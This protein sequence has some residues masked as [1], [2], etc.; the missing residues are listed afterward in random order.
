M[1]LRAVLVPV[2]LLLAG[3]PEDDK[4]LLLQFPLVL[5][6]SGTCETATSKDFL[7]LKEYAVRLTFMHRQDSVTAAT[8]SSYELVCDYV[9]P[10]STAGT[11]DIVVPSGLGSRY[12]VR[13]EA[14]SE[15]AKDNFVL[16][17]S[18]QAEDLDLTRPDAKIFL[19]PLSGL[20]SGYSCTQEP[21]VRRAFHTA[22]ALP[23]GGVLIVG[24]L[25]VSDGASEKIDES[26]AERVA[27][28]ATGRVEV[29]EPKSQRFLGFSDT[30]QL[31]RR[32]AFHQAFLLPS[33]AAGPYRI[34]LLGGVS[35]SKGSA[36]VWLRQ[37]G[38][39]LRPFVFSPHDDAEAAPAEILTYTPGGENDPGSFTTTP[40][41]DLPRPYFPNARLT[42]D[43]TGIIGLG[44]GASYKA[45]YSHPA[46][47]PAADRGFPVPDVRPFFINLPACN[48]PCGETKPICC[49]KGAL[50][51]QC[52][53]A[54]D[55]D[56]CVYKTDYRAEVLP[57]HVGASLAQLNSDAFL[58]VGGDMTGTDTAQRVPAPRVAGPIVP[59]DVKRHLVFQTLTPIGP[60][61]T[62]ILRAGGYRLTD[63]TS[64]Q[65]FAAATPE[66]TDP[67][68]WI[69]ADF[70]LRPVAEAAFVP[71]AYHAA[72]QLNDGA[73]LLTGGSAG[74]CAFNLCPH[75]QT[76]VFEWAGSGPRLRPNTYKCPGADAER[77]K[78]LAI[79][80]LGH[81]ATLLTNGTVI[82]TGGITS[83]EDTTSTGVK[84][85]VP[86][87]LR[88]PEV[89]NPRTGL[90]DDDQWRRAPGKVKGD[91]TCK[92]RSAIPAP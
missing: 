26:K 3:C 45:A 61:N 18:G 21:L 84:F 27:V 64:S 43:G 62:G 63:D 28:D 70:T 68:E 36:A 30:N 7:P 19:R 40:L 50:K 14:F 48:P 89:F 12:A 29:Y 47:A 92:L 25:V 83:V 75:G 32:R 82:I 37:S 13:A 56:G 17:Y 78:R 54:T 67:L 4:G 20:H 39:T 57:S 44:G 33:R 55:T 35:P 80:R 15:P 9:F 77:C 60:A 53:A 10:R 8:L 74:T 5:E 51:P 24:G 22:T 79:P 86:K 76:L 69:A 81:Q 38:E 91:K 31:N 52:Y 87:I 11:V 42:S 34:L 58:L 16:E 66:A 49:E 1:S 72:T 6:P 2:C 65:R 59:F 46:K 23:N 85:S 88:T 41:P 90:A 71:V 73:V